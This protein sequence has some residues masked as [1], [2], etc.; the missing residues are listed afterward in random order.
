MEIE[1]TP[2]E[3]V[4]IVTPRVFQDPRGFSMETFQRE[5]FE[6]AGLPGDFVQD[7]LSYSN[8]NTLRGLHFQNPAGQAKLVQAIQGEIFDVAVDIRVGSPTF[9]QWFGLRLS[10]TN[11]RQMYIAEG[12]AHGFCVLSETAHVTYKCTDYYAPAHEGGILWSDPEIGIDW[13]VDNPLLSEKDRTYPRLQD[14]APENLPGT[15]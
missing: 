2:I 4:W 15:D 5:R 11:N 3:G 6:A 10:G 8:R 12:L 7:N 13:P 1:A 9:G 14:L